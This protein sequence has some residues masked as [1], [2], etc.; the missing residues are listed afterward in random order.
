MNDCTD[1]RKINKYPGCKECKYKADGESGHKKCE[2]AKYV[3]PSH[4]PYGLLYGK[5][6]CKYV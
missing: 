6:K 1:N 5:E 4:K 2:C 3:Y